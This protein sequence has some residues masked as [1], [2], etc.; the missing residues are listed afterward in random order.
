MVPT[1]KSTSAWRGENLATA[2]H[3]PLVSPLA[4][5]ALFTEALGAA[6]EHRAHGSFGPKRIGVM[7][8]F[9]EAAQ[10][11]EGEH[12]FVPHS[13]IPEIAGGGHGD[14]QGGANGA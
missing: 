8:H 2:A 14:R 7:P 13:G 1:T 11:A 9:T 4:R 3:M 12:V 10:A 6:A 5:Q